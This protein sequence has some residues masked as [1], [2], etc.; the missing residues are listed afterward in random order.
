MSKLCSITGR[1]NI[2]LAILW[3]GGSMW[4]K[5]IGTNQL[6]FSPMGFLPR[7]GNISLPVQWSPWWCRLCCIFHYREEANVIGWSMTISFALPVRCSSRIEITIGW[8]PSKWTGVW[9]KRCLVLKKSFVACI[10][11]AYSYRNV[12][13]LLSSDYHVIAFDW[14]GMY[15]T[16]TKSL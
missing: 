8:F 7:Y 1:V 9:N 13:P 14:L 3:T 12:I 4:K 10:V 15:Q 11:Q 2:R 6:S 5:E 16:L